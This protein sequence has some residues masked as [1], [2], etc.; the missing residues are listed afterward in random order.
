M[1]KSRE[2]SVLQCPKCHSDN[3]SRPQYSR[4]IFAISFLLL[5]FPLPFFKKVS[6]CF[7]CGNEFKINKI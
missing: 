5:G 2:S 3:V 7:E 4:R 1:N 6:Y